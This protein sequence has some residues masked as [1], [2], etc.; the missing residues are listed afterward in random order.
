MSLPALSFL[1]LLS[2][3]IATMEAASGPVGFILELA[4]APMTIWWAEK[5]SQNVRCGRA[6][7][8]TQSNVVIHP[9]VA[10]R[11]RDVLVNALVAIMSH[12]SL[13]AMKWP[14]SLLKLFV[15]FKP[16]PLP[17]IGCP[18]CEALAGRTSGKVPHVRAENWG[19]AV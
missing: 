10:G 13:S 7:E 4:V 9:E 11:A 1:C 8:T 18:W 14:E 2:S 5:E 19:F 3:V 6:S 12:D 16:I 17:K 15:V